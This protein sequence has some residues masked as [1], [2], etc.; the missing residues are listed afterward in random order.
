MSLK[1]DLRS[2]KTPVGAWARE[3][4]PNCKALYGQLRDAATPHRVAPDGWGDGRDQ[5]WS[6]AGTACGTMLR[7]QLGD[8]GWDPVTVMGAVRVLTGVI[9]TP[10]AAAYDQLGDDGLSQLVAAAPD[11]GDLRHAAATAV[12]WALAEQHFRHGETA[13]PLS[14]ADLADVDHL[15]DEVA[16]AEV[17]DY[18]HAVAA[19][20]GGELAGQ[21]GELGH[22]A[23]GPAYRYPRGADADL[24]AGTTIV[25]VKT[26]VA[27]PKMVDVLQPVGYALLSDDPVDH[28]AWAYPRSGGLLHMGLQEVLDTAAGEPV[29]L[30][31]SRAGFTAALEQTPSGIR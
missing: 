29:G 2:A 17:V 8:T 13:N 10:G 3:T 25:E 4:F 18:V 22:V 6:W 24:L 14:D 28:V 9:R 23:F 19:G 31:D 30:E 27:R 12:V 26:T 1:S 21:I 5:R 7:W 15:L 16:P 20:P 11:I